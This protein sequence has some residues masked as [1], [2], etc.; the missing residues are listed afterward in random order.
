MHK[1]ILFDW[2]NTLMIDDKTQQGKMR[3][4]DKIQLVNGASETLRKLSSVYP[5][6]VATGAGD[7]TIKD[8][9]AAFAR[10]E[11][12]VF[13]KGYFNRQNIPFLK[14]SSDFYLAIS[15]ALGVKPQEL[16]MIGDSLEK[17]IIPAKQAGLSALWLNHHRHTPP[18][19]VVAITQLQ[20]LESLLL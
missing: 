13:I 5:L 15:S 16:C 7:S 1:A 11:I 20:A 14:G 6:Y 17:D 8:I 12:D 3:Y 9:H 18:P 2:G 19:Q 10:A 4:W